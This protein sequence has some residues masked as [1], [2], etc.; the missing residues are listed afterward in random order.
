MEEILFTNPVVCGVNLP[1]SSLPLSPSLS[2]SL[3][4]CVSVLRVCV[5]HYVVFLCP[6]SMPGSGSVQVWFLQPSW[7]Q[8]S[9]SVVLRHPVS[10]HS[11]WELQAM[12]RFGKKSK[13]TNREKTVCE[14][15]TRIVAS[16]NSRSVSYYGLPLSPLWSLCH[17]YYITVTVT[18]TRHCVTVSLCH[19]V[20]VTRPSICLCPTAPLW[21]GHDLAEWLLNEHACWMCVS[22]SSWLPVNFC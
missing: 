19:C 18:V 12:V 1:I 6:C 13:E 4:L 14:K 2:L 17:C 20:T 21:I 10:P 8:D 9:H 5:L 3:S 22:F 15:V 11:L 16:A 7:K